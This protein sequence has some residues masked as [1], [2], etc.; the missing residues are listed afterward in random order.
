[1]EAKPEFKS[2]EKDGLTIERG[3]FYSEAEEK[4]PTL[5]MKKTGA[6]GKLPV[7]ICCTAPAATRRASAA[8]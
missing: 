2:E 1:M 8:C 3:T 7:V 5:I 4:V 6:A